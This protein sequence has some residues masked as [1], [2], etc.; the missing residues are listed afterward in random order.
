MNHAIAGAGAEGPAMARK[1]WFHCYPDTALGDLSGLSSDERNVLL[2]LQLMT[3]A[4]GGPVRLNRKYLARSCA[5][6]TRKFNAVLGNLL[7]LGKV[8]AQ[9]GQI[10]IADL[11]HG[12]GFETK[13]EKKRHQTRAKNVEI[14]TGFPNENNEGGADSRARARGQKQL[15]LLGF[16]KSIRDRPRPV[17]S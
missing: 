14:L 2:T 16:P 9:D 10:G 11:R 8:R 13:N 15:L 12:H 17:P 4:A 5:L 6:T 7:E 3:E 1:P